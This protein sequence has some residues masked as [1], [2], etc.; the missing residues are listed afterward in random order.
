MKTVR[1]IYIYAVALVSLEV[2][3]WAVIGLGR[4]VFERSTV[5][6]NVEQ[7]AG[8]LSFILVGLPVFLLHWW[9]AQRDAGK[10][11]EEHFSG[12]RAFFLYAMAV[13]LWAPVVQNLLA[14]LN[15]AFA[16]L[17]KMNTRYIAVGGSQGWTDNIV[18][19]VVN[20]LLGWYILSVIWKDWA[21]QPQG[22]SF[23]NM[24]RIWRYLWMLYGL[25]L[26]FSGIL[27]LLLYVFELGDVVGVGGASILVNGLTFTL[28]GIPIW[29]A[30]WRV[31]TASL[32]EKAEKESLLRLIV[33]YA[34]S[35]VAVVMALSSTGVLV[36]EILQDILVDSTSSASLL[37]RI[38]EPLAA[39][40]PS[41]LVWLFYGRVLNQ[42]M[43]AL[44][45]APRRAGMR[46]LYRYVL[47]LLGL[48]AAFTGL[49]MLVALVLDLA[50]DPGVVWGR[51]VQTNLADSL[52]TLLVGIPVWLRNWLPMNREAANEDEAGDHARR[53]VIRKGYL[54]LALFVGV[55]GVMIT[56]GTVI[57]YIFTTVLGDPI[58]DFALRTLQMVG[59]LILFA[60]LLAYHWQALR[61]D[62][63]LSTRLLAAQHAEFSVV[64]FEPAVGGFAEVI[65][66][67]LR[68]E[69]PDV[70]VAVHPVGENLDDSLAGAGAVILPA[71]LAANPP[72]AI[73]IW[74]QE[75]GGTRLV[76][77]APAENW[78]WIGVEDEK[79]EAFGKQTAKAVEQLAE[80]QQEVRVRSRS[81]WTIMGYIFAVAAVLG[82]LCLLTAIVQEAF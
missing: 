17:F 82:A 37:N 26:A 70:P 12:T 2:V 53:S 62:G 78:V 61:A 51:Y 46:R 10:T 11:P 32:S 81:A 68:Q 31:I 8:A 73:R 24:R 39:S 44:P 13:G 72:E 57:F 71:S 36:A 75:F 9:W 63:R 1:R 80:G 50:L 54:Y 38:A 43:D 21:A 27:Q 66:E 64:I 40:V 29:V 19:A 76:V 16:L 18:A 67:V 14:I 45:D 34:I 65:A 55:I 5:G 7:L 60:I 15:R 3:A 6:G 33:L 42:E 74:L 79:L 77:P 56:A 58:N 28:A 4:S 25:V 69:T 41:V 22:D 47:S 20:A 52:A 59:A 30:A 49:Q 23:P 35:F 48:G